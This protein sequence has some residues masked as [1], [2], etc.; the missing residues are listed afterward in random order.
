[1]KLAIIGAGR[2]GTALA[3][4]LEAAGHDLVVASRSIE[5]SERVVAGLA[6][7]RAATPADAV[8]S[9]EVVILAVRFPDVADALAPMGVRLDGV[10]LWSCVNALTP[11]FSGLAVGFDDSAAETVARQVPGARVVA[12]LPPFAD[13]LAAGTPDYAGRV[14]TTF[15]CGDE[16]AAK[17]VVAGLVRDIGAE[18]VDA[19]PLASARLVEPAMMLLVR[20][21]YGA[22]PPRD[23]ALALLERP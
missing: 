16:A 11:D 21:A 13:A 5:D 6:R 14:P 9:A 2:L 20:L 18:P 17:T 22:A 15:L 10:V 3:T 12:A 7:A 23:V 1:V 8:V 19:G 4:R